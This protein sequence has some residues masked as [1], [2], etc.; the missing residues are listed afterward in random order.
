MD[1]K[2]VQK[3]IWRNLFAQK[4]AALG[5]LRNFFGDHFARPYMVR[6]HAPPLN[7]FVGG[8]Y[9]K[10][11]FPGVACPFLGVSYFRKKGFGVLGTVFGAMGDGC[12]SLFGGFLISGKQGWPISGGHSIALGPVV[13]FIVFIGIKIVPRMVIRLVGGF[14]PSGDAVCGFKRNIPAKREYH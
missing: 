12:M 9:Q 5:D 4:R 3:S 2:N 13:G 14:L 8:R 7:P 11:G 10:G 6:G 1:K